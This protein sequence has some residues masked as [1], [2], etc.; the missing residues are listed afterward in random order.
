[1]VLRARTPARVALITG[2][3][4]RIGAAIVQALHAA[5]YNVVIHHRASAT[6][7]RVLAK[8][9]NAV[10]ADSALVLRADLLKVPQLQALAQAA[11][12]KWGRLDLLVNNASSYF[13]TPLPTLSEQQFDDLVGSNF[14]APLFLAQACR[15]YLQKSEGAIVGVLDIHARDAPRRGHSAYAAAKLAHWSL[16]ETLA[17]ELAPKIRCNGV[18]PGHVQAPVQALPSAAELADLADKRRQLPHIPLARYA[19]PEEIASVVV[20]LAST[21]ASYV[22]GVVIPVDGGRRL[23]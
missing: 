11:Q 6:E 17:L 9:L 18:A 14:K 7:A 2:G 12:E 8:A 23:G 20:F 22:T 19:S 4:R 15:P 16:I 5:G 10:R 13:A 21:A 1:M 3:G